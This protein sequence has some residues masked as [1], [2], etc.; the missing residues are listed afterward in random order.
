MGEAPRKRCRDRRRNRRRNVYRERKPGELGRTVEQC[1]GKQNPFTWKTRCPRGAEYLGEPPGLTA[2]RT[3]TLEEALATDSMIG[4]RMPAVMLPGA[5][6][7]WGPGEV[8]RIKRPVVDPHL[9]DI[10]PVLSHGDDSVNAATGSTAPRETLWRVNRHHR[11]RSGSVEPIKKRWRWQA[12]KTVQR[13]QRQARQHLPRCNEQLVA[14]WRDDT[15]M[16]LLGPGG[17]H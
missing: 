16:A 1:L 15:Q 8:S 7:S 6:A 4:N 2:P 12:K 9:S 10:L 13:N 17:L 3:W 5:S 14:W 11:D